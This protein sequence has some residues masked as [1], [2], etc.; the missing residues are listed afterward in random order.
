MPSAHHGALVGAEHHITR[1][2]C[3]DCG[4]FSE[5]REGD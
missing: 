3:E 2:C 4:E 1:H 5:S